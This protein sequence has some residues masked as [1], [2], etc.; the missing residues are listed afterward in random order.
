MS[1]RT[2]EFDGIDA[3]GLERLSA[4]NKQNPSHGHKVVKS[5]TVAESGFRNQNYVREHQPF[6]I[7]EPPQLLG[8]DEAPNPTEIA[9]GALGSCVSV[10][11]VANATA[12][13]VALSRVEVNV[14]GDIDISATWGV[15]D[16]DPEKRLGVHT[17]RIHVT[18][19]G[20]ADEA[21]LQEIT[22][23]AVKWS[24]VV[25]TFTRSAA[26]ETTLNDGGRSTE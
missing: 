14:E 3:E 18:L 8:D 15:G 20:D 21:T 17:I 2:A 23:N 22:D 1:T 25:N 5:R 4:K 11:L 26:L 6:L 7:S 12:R 19:E 9:L 16:L 13:E 10:G 24:P